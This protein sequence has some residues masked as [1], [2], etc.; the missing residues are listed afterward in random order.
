MMTSTGAHGRNS[1]RPRPGRLDDPILASKITIPDM[2]DWVVS[3]PRIE[4][5]IAEG[6]QGPL[7]VVTGPPGAGKTMAIASWATGGGA[8]PIAW[9]TLDEYDNRPR[10]FWSHIVA[11]LRRAGVTVPAACTRGEAGHAFLLRLAA[12]LTGQDPPVIL[13][14]DDLH[15]VT[16]QPVMAALAYMVR[17]A[18]WGLHLLV[19][20]RMDP[21]L[22]LH[23]YRLTGELT[24][25]RADDLAFSVPEAALLMEQHR[26]TL[27]AEALESVTARNEG[28]AAGLRMAAITLG[29]HPDPAQFVHDL[30]THHTPVTGYLVEE[31][32]NAQPAVVRDLLLRTS[33]LD[34]VNADIAVD[35]A[36]D[37]SA[38]DVLFALARQNAFVQSNGRG[39]YRYHTLFRDVLRLKLRSEQPAGVAGLHRRAAGWYRREGDLAAAV[40][41]ALQAGD[42]QLTARIL[43]DELAIGHLLEP[44]GVELPVDVFRHTPE[45][46]VPPQTLLASAATAVAEVRDHAAEASLAAAERILEQ[47]PDDQEGPSRLAA[48][49]IR[50]ILAR[51]AG[52]LAA[53]AVAAAAAEN[54]LANLAESAHA[55]YAQAYAQMLSGRGTVEFWSGHLDRATSL[56]EKAA[57]LFDAEDTGATHSSYEPASCRGYLALL[58]SLRGRLSEAADLGTSAIVVPRDCRAAQPCPPAAVAL[59]QVYL[60]RNELNK[61]H[62]LLKLADMGLRDHP[63]KLVSAV[64]CLMAAR[65]ELAGGHPSAAADLLMR[66]RSGWLVPP[67]LSH[68]LTVTESQACAAAGDTRAAMDA[69]RR[70]APE[71]ALDAA[72]A[73]A[74]AYLAAAD[75]GTAK[76]VLAAA[77]TL[78][79]G[80]APDR[81]RVEAWLINAC[82]AFRGGDAAS[83]RRSLQRALHLAEP[84]RLRL[85]FAME[86][87]WLKPA[88]E[89]HADL[90]HTYRKVLEPGLVIAGPS[91]VPRSPGGQPP[92]AAMVQLSERERDVLRLVE[93]MLDT[94]EI[95]A[96]LY[97]SVN[98][99]KTHLKNITRKLG[100]ADRRDA[101]RRARET[102]LL[103]PYLLFTQVTVGIDRR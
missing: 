64:A 100:A 16:D 36:G 7:T 59:A 38:A 33:I 67:W 30:V 85:P 29:T 5:R 83:G 71:H 46:S 1:L 97:I 45:G 80:G 54:L 66:A 17:N 21:L 4:K 40:R 55:E 77:A 63:D 56:L 14:L 11:A 60:E 23:Q 9:V 84:Q 42:G 41:H 35:L 79:D 6:A 81:I 102:G 20:S 15:L 58:E 51:R 96:E 48:A 13:V 86:R 3:R 99:V 88:L 49:T 50:L 22:P 53:A 82:L 18:R 27:P 75:P 52:D 39:S 65:A 72:V 101:V 37:R 68:L 57:S 62:S 69:A 8:G 61:T 76:R 91:P 90:A 94:D 78:D 25:I 95:A 73:L 43:V 19:A 24:E 32:L 2:P 34:T 93:Q 28:W 103:L 89:R 87:S 31:V 26:V 10:R 98:T 92:S 12:A 44:D 70:A 74:R 47:F